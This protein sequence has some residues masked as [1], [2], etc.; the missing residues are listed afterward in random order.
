M[1]ERTVND[2]PTGYV[3]IE[4]ADDRLGG[5]V[6][7]VVRLVVLNRYAELP[8]AICAIESLTRCTRALNCGKAQQNE[9]CDQPN[10]SD[11]FD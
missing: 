9:H 3:S 7:A 11:D 10:R 5:W 2:S 1:H 6:N 4:N 8:Q